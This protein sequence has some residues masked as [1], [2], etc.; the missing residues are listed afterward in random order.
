MKVKVLLLCSVSVLFFAG[1]AATRYGP[2]SGSAFGY[3]ESK[4]QR[5]MY[6][7]SFKGNGFTSPTTAMN[8]FLYRCA[9]ITVR[10]GYDYF[11][12]AEGESNPELVLAGR[13]TLT[14][15]QYTGTIKLYKGEKPADDP[16]AYDAKELMENL[17]PQIIRQ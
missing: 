8:Y 12:I 11:I 2:A 6:N 16:N 13:S 17:E 3:R 9:E 15:P 1:C 7:V 5:D 4:I 14:K 10:D